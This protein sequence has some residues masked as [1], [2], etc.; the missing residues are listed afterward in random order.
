MI[1]HKGFGHHYGRGLGK[2]RGSPTHRAYYGKPA[3]LFKDSDK[4]GVANVFD[5]KPFDKKRQDVIAPRH[6]GIGGLSGL[7][8]KQEYARQ[9]GVYQKQLEEAERVQ[10][11][12]Q[13]LWIKQQ[14][15]ALR[16]QQKVAKRS[17][18]S[19]TMNVYVLP[20]PQASKVTTFVKAPEQVKVETHTDIARTPAPEKKTLPQTSTAIGQQKSTYFSRLLNRVVKL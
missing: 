10:R 9:Y 16:Q 20:E 3:A 1:R 5:C 6:G 17:S 18:G 12:Q 14:Q 2:G 7:Y 13:E 4:D 8:A 15:E 19:Y 11:Q